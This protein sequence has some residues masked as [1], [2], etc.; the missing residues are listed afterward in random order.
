MC[1]DMGFQL[2]SVFLQKLEIQFTLELQGENVSLLPS[3]KYLRQLVWKFHLVE[4]LR[5]TSV[6]QKHAEKLYILVVN[7]LRAA[8]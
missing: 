6:S 5:L 3:Q 2:C 4:L 7:G 8:L 1:S